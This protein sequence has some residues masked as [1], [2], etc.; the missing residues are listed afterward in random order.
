MMVRA[1]HR[2]CPQKN[3]DTAYIN[4]VDTGNIDLELSVV[5]SNSTTRK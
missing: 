2:G 5:N 4:N 3:V 1:I